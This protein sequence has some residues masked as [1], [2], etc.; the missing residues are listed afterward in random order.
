LLAVRDLVA[1]YGKKQV[2]GGVTLDVGE[3]EIVA[4]IGHNGAGKSTLLKAVF[5]MLPAWSGAVLFEGRT[6]G[7]DRLPRLLRAG[8][9]YVPQGSR[10]F[11]DLTVREN[12]EV[13][14][15][16][17]RTR[18]ERTTATRRVLAMFPALTPL[19]A[20]R[21]GTL[22]GGERQMLALSMGLMTAPRLLLMDEPSLG[23]APPVAREAL[24]TIQRA[25]QEGGVSV[26]I[27]EQ[28]VREVLK[29]AQRVV[30]LRNGRVSYSGPA[31]DLADGA[32][33]KSAYL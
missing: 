12:V 29:I 14:G 8:V 32:K 9:S 30:V 1:G 5:G 4:L 10:V 26:L 16:R 17:L 13:G 18:G 6:L 15:V 19:V 21:A 2:I 28:K 22:S 31:A 11:S 7:R 25:S 24:G 33:L 3:G 23:L 20:R 27:A